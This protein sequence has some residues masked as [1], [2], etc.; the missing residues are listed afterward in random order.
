MP[1]EVSSDKVICFR[2]GKAFSRRR[3]F[4]PVSYAILYKGVGYLPFCRDCIETMYNTY[5]SQCNN[6]KDAVHQM[7]RKLDVFWSESLFDSVFRQNTTRTVMSQ[8]LAKLSTVSY[9]G[10]SYDDTLASEGTLWLFSSSAPTL[11]P[12]SQPLVLETDEDADT[13]SDEPVSEEVVAFWGPGYTPNMYRGLE[14]RRSYWMSRFPQGADMDIGTEALIRQICSLELDINRDRAAGK[15]VDKSVTALNTLLGSAN[16]KPKQ[17][18][19]AAAGLVEIPL[20]VWLHRYENERPLPE[21]DDDMKDVNKIQKYVFTWLGHVC[22]ML[23]KKNGFSR[24]YEQE[25]QR[26]RVERP[27]FVDEDDEEMIMDVLDGSIDEPDDEVG[28]V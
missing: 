16:L 7:C 18:D 14:Q 3:S 19:D 6:A 27:E 21:I 8:Y 26:L 22:K 24:L 11:T 15:A 9:A 23:G 5:L 20:G 1:I 4:F 12:E 25:V 2:C 13:D 17:K 28:D 10:K